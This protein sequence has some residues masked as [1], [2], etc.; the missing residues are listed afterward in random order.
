[1][2]QYRSGQIGALH[3]AIQYDGF[4][5]VLGQEGDG[6]PGHDSILSVHYHAT[7][8]QRRGQMTFVIEGGTSDEA[9]GR[10]RVFP[11]GQR[12]RRTA[13]YSIVRQRPA[14][15]KT[16]EGPEN[17]ASARSRAGTRSGG[18]GGRNSHELRDW[19]VGG[20]VLVGIEL[21]GDSASLTGLGSQGAQHPPTAP[22][23]HVF[24]QGDFRWHGKSQFHDRPFRERRLGV[25]ENSTA[26]QVLGKTGRSPSIE[27]NRQRQVH[28]ET[29]RA[30]AFKTIRI[31]AHCSSFPDL[32]LSDPWTLTLSRI[33]PAG[34]FQSRSRGRAV[35]IHRIIE[36]LNQ[37]FNDPMT[38]CLVF[39]PVAVIP[40]M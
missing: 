25:E 17:K 24:P 12:T 26:T 3:P 5:A 28:F 1:M 2:A 13:G 37:C 35:E 11:S 14:L 18:A 31:C 16:R 19:L 32:A 22:N 8:F 20:Q 4:F 36:T 9:A 34:K 10:Q 40:K 23:R 7:N 38:Q 29:L 33:E 27:V 6:D 39:P 30:S 21:H 15:E